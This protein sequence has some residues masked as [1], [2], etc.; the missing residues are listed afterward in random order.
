[1]I[2]Y[3]KD[4]RYDQNG[5]ATHDRYTHTHTLTHTLVTVCVVIFYRQVTAAVAATH[6]STMKNTAKKYGVIGI[7]EGQ[8]VSS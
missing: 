7:D 3:A 8:F 5:V 2:K 1:M 6:L 4:N